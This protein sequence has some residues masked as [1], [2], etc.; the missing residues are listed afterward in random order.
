MRGESLKT[1]PWRKTEASRLVSSSTG[2]HAIRGRK[3]YRS[4][5]DTGSRFSQNKNVNTSP[6]HHL[7]GLNFSICDTYYS[8][9]FRKDQVAT[10][11]AVQSL[12]DLDPGRCEIM[13]VLRCAGYF[14]S[15]GST[16]PIRRVCNV[17]DWRNQKAH[18]RGEYS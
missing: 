7:T 12:L 9:N 10:W 13:C 16:R 11:T 18:C 14:G 5:V 8:V 1:I 3:W 2:K 6:L 15:C 17:P 4:G